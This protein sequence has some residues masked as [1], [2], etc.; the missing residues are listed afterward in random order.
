MSFSRRQ[1]RMETSGRTCWNSRVPSSETKSKAAKVV[2]AGK[3]FGCGSS[4]EVAVSA[5]K[6][7]FSANPTCTEGITDI[8]AGAGVQAVIAKSFAFSYGRVFLAG[9][10]QAPHHHTACHLTPL[11]AEWLI[12]CP[13]P[14]RSWVTHS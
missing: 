7:T 6:G 13:M 9:T 11:R 4:R 12:L 10:I 2:V 5:L 14:R 1:R 3:A 8:I